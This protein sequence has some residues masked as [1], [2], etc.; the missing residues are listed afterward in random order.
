MIKKRCRVNAYIEIAI[1]RKTGFAG[2]V[3]DIE[4]ML[5]AGHSVGHF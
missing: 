3:Y 1:G 2:H 4:M 5:I